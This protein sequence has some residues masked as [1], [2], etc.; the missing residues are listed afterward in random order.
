M[1]SSERD[2]SQNII[3]P[4]LSARSKPH[5]GPE[6]LRMQAQMLRIKASL[7]VKNISNIWELA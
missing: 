2:L 6:E 3:N 4:E 5:I 7:Q 1:S